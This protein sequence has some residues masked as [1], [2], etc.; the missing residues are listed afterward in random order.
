MRKQES[1]SAPDGIELGGEPEGGIG[2]RR[3]QAHLLPMFR[4]ES[5]RKTAEE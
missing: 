1:E 5:S 4:G 3:P 2:V